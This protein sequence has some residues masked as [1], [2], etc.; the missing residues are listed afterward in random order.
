MTVAGTARSVKPLGA[1]RMAKATLRPAS[2]TDDSAISTRR[3]GFRAGSSALDEH[4]PSVSVRAGILARMSTRSPSPIVQQLAS[5]RCRLCGGGEYSWFPSVVVTQTE[6]SSSNYFETLV[7]RACRKT[8]LFVDLQQ[9]ERLNA[10][11]ILR[12]E[13]GTPHR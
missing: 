13:G 4:A 5:Q 10:H 1:R 2:R 11:T 3:S 7:C 9:L 12:V 6:G 8:D